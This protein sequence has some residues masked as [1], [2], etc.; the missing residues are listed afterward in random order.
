MVSTDCV[1]PSFTHLITSKPNAVEVCSRNLWQGGYQ[2]Q[3]GQTH[4]LSSL[5]QRRSDDALL[6]LKQASEKQPVSTPVS[7]KQEKGQR[8]CFQVYGK[9][10]PVNSSPNKLGTCNQQ[11]VKRTDEPFEDSEGCVSELYII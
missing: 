11:Q 10:V 8:T 5:A 6:R 4:C 1:P 9:V 3:A 7:Q 2:S